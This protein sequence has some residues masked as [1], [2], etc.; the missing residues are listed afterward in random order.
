MN[1]KHPD[2]LR[3]IDFHAHMLDAEIVRLCASKNAITGF[4]QKPPPMQGKFS[5]FYAPELQ[6]EE[7]DARGI[8]MHVLFTGPVFMS[9]WWAD[10]Q[11]ALEL[12]RRM[13]AAVADW[14]RRHSSRF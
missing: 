11:T 6:I 3:V 14:V 8:D 5:K 2:A 12:T 13:N 7:M 9:T 4:G 10:A 1:R